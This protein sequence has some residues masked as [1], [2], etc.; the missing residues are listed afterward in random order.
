MTEKLDLTIIKAKF[1]CFLIHSRFHDL[2]LGTPELNF[3]NE[4]AFEALCLRAVLGSIPALAE[5]DLVI[6]QDELLQFST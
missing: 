3:F 5:S 4:S 2:S 1:F 6:L